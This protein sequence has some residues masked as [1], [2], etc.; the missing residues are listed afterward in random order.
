LT[1]TKK[2]AT[3]MRERLFKIVPDARDRALLSTFHSFATDILR[4]HGSHF[5]LT[6]EFEILE[7][8]EQISI[9]KRLL[10][11]NEDSYSR[12]LSAE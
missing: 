1:F 8:S 9:V 2:A 3:E 12:I 10:A 4:Q 5:G 6:P 11:S 7:K